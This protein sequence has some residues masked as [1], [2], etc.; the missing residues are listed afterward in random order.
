MNFMLGVKTFLTKL[1]ILD[2]L[3]H[4]PE[5]EVELVVIL[6]AHPHSYTDTCTGRT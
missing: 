3:Q 6:T 2:L 4:S 5:G 1:K